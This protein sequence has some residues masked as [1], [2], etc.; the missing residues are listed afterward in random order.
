[1]ITNPA[2]AA[3]APKQKSLTI[4][5]SQLQ[6]RL[7]TLY[8]IRYRWLITEDLNKKWRLSNGI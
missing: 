1:M 8:R 6:E 3:E 4:D 7:L 5:I 2:Q